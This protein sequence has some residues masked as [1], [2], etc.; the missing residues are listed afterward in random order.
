MVQI[1]EG[2][3]LELFEIH[4]FLRFILEIKIKVVFLHSEKIAL[5]SGPR[6]GVLASFFPSLFSF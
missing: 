2:L 4:F 5:E 1:L 3:K 6:F